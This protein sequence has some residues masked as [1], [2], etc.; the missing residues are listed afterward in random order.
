MSRGLPLALL[1]LGLLAGCGP[2][3]SDEERI[4]ARIEAMQSALSE[5]NVR[6]F[7]AP[8]ADDF[9]ASTRN[10]D[11]RAARLLLRREMMAH[12]RLKARL[13][14][15]EI[16]LVGDNRATATMHAVT[17]GGSGLIPETGGWYLVTTG[18]RLDDDEWMLIS[19]SWETIAGRR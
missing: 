5:G 6:A 13:A 8:V 10:L 15:I 7:V 19:A 18:W 2:D 14:D 17:T 16:T 3:A 4:R 12:D 9:T 11:R 1:V